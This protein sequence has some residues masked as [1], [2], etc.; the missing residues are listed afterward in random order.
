MTSVHNL[1]V[2]FANTTYS[3][4]G[5]AL[6]T[7]DYAVSWCARKT[8]FTTTSFTGEGF[9]GTT[10]NYTYNTLR[11]EAKGQGA[12]WVIMQI[13]FLKNIAYKFLGKHPV[14]KEYIG[15]NI[16]ADYNSKD[17]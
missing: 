9:R 11:W 14:I 8:S 1:L 7:Y 5:E 12:N 4:L 10:G 16:I 15:N 13:I 6:D 2:P 17:K 3:I